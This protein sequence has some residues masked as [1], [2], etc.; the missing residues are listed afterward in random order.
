MRFLGI[1]YG[2]KRIGIAISD[3]SGAF[4]FPRKVLANDRKVIDSIGKIIEIEDVEEIVMG[5][6]LDLAGEK[7]A[8]SNEIDN[9]V[10]ALGNTFKM[11]VHKQKEFMT[12][13][14]A[15]GTKGKET[16]NARVTSFKKP[17]KLDASAAALILQRYL[18]KR[19][20]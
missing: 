9:F 17:K 8:I 13:M 14:H 15:H 19:N 16:N 4:A 1:D 7:N 2:V 6:S 10:R 18:D 12:S 20:N 5:E 11:P 3:D